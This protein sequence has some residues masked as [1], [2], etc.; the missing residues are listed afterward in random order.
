MSCIPLNSINQDF[1]YFFVRD[2]VL[3]YVTDPSK[4]RLNYVSKNS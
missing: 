3:F 1:M 4:L 2:E